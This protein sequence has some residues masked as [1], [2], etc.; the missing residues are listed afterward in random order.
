MLIKRVQ[1]SKAL[2]PH[3]IW[4]L[5]T[6]VYS[7]ILIEYR[8]ISSKGK[9]R[10]RENKGKGEKKHWSSSSFRIVFKFVLFNS[11]FLP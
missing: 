3:L 9:K 5:G 4:Y 8:I 10:E 7:F 11:T 1:I 2:P 6:T